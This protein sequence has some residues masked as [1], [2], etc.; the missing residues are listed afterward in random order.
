M[1]DHSAS[2]QTAMDELMLVLDQLPPAL[3]RLSDG[4][5]AL[6]EAVLDRD[7]EH[8]LLLTAEQEE[9]GAH[10]AHLERKRQRLQ[11]Q[12]ERA[13]DVSGLAGIL[14]VG[15]EE[16]EHG[17]LVETVDSI[18]QEIRRVRQE[19]SHTALLLNAVIDLTRRA[20]TQLSRQIGVEPSYH[21]FRVS[22]SEVRVQSETRNSKPETIAHHEFQL[23]G[24]GF[25][26][27]LETRNS[28]PETRP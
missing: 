19:E 14:A 22:S 11:R 2:V 12:L 17:R 4:F 23:P 28:K 10:V 25:R 15:E 27:Q 8:F 9:A 1:S 21:E 16:E 26:V 3:A 13:L 24:S 6:R 7:I 5:V 18:R 20:R